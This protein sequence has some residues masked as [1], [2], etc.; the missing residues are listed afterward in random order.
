MSSPVITVIEQAK[1]EVD[2]RI[3]EL[4]FKAHVYEAFRLMAELLELEAALLKIRRWDSTDPADVIEV[5]AADLL[6]Q[7][8][9]L[10]TP[11]LDKKKG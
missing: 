6:A 2:G 8:L 7:K 11:Q 1:A 10:K 9:R 3:N 5:K 4:L